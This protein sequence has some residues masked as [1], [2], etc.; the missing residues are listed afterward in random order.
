MKIHDLM[1]NIVCKGERSISSDDIRRLCE[2]PT[3]KMIEQLKIQTKTNEEGKLIKD[4]SNED[5]VQIWLKKT[6]HL[7]NRTSK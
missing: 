3:Q 7:E 6:S 5:V 2:Q 4:I 1:T